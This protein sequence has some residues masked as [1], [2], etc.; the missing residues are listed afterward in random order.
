MAIQ[1]MTCTSTG[2]SYTGDIPAT[3]TKNGTVTAMGFSFGAVPAGSTG[4]KFD[5]TSDQAISFNA[6]ALA[7]IYTGGASQLLANK[8]ACGGS[9]TT[10]MYGSVSLPAAATASTQQITWSSLGVDPSTTLF[11]Q[12]GITETT[13][14]VAATV[15]ITI[16]NVSLY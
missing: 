6:A 10:T 5:Y 9:A 13:T 8:A 11:V 12:W 3:G 1:L 2:V 14:L 16:S 15:N 4:I 7:G